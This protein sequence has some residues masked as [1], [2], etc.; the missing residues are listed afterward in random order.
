MEQNAAQSSDEN[1][2]KKWYKKKRIVLPVGVLVVIAI[3]SSG[4]EEQ[5]SET[6]SQDSVAES[7]EP[8]ATSLVS[9]TIVPET[10][11]V[12]TTIPE[13]DL[14][15]IQ[16]VDFLSV[17]ETGREELD[18]A[19]TELQ[20][21]KALRD[22]DRSLCEVLSSYVAN[23]WIGVVEDIGANGEGKAYLS[24]EIDDNARVQTWNN[25][26]SDIGDNTLIP[27]NSEIFDVLVP[28]VEGDRVRF[29]AKF[30]RGSD[31]CLK[32]GNLTETF[33]GIDP[34]FI[35]K[36]IQVEKLEG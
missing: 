14:R 17:I 34:E 29:S 5:A 11:V 20:R 21:S 18:R 4:N 7:I 26:F 10:T 27:E 8:V 19:T 13:V 6:R 33:Y 30:L 31:T 36:F 15:P 9:T 32:A 1:V 23:D 12:S 24:L 22:R 2:K 28:L 16:Q 35:V 25:A 3:A